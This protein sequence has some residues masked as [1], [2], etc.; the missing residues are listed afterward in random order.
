MNQLRP[1]LRAL[2]SAVC[3]Y[4]LLHDHVAGH[5][6]HRASELAGVETMLVTGCNLDDDAAVIIMVD[7]NLR[8]ENILPSE[9]AF[10]FKLKLE[11][12]KSDTLKSISQSHMLLQKWGSHRQTA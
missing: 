8:R 2:N 10:A 9:R 12:I 11:A 7:S 5:R 3:L 6:R 4:P 1:Q